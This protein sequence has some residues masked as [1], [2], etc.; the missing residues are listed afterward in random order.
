MIGWHHQ[1]NGHK[2]KQAPGVGDGKESWRAAVHGVTKSQT[3]LRSGQLETGE[4]RSLS[5]DQ[6]FGFYSAA[7][8]VFGDK[9]ETLHYTTDKTL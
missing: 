1:I 9:T 4:R 5:C 2:F 3:R 7:M 6:Y 8:G